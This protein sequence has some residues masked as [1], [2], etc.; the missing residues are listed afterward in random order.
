MPGVLPAS[1]HFRVHSPYIYIR[2]ARIRWVGWRTV[3]SRSFI[4]KEKIEILSLV[5]FFTMHCLSRPCRRAA[6]GVLGLGPRGREFL[7][8]GRDGP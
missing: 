2:P 8:A 6:V 7:V 3:S 5:A 4:Q 1:L